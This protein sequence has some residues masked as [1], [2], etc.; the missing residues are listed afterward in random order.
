M[1]FK[2]HPKTT[3]PKGSTLYQSNAIIG[4]CPMTID[5]WVHLKERLGMKKD[6]WAREG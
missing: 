3:H 5:N 1:S 6:R 2:V 4:S